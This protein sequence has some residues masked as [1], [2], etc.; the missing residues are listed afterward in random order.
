MEPFLLRY[1]RQVYNGLNVMV[2]ILSAGLI[3]YLSILAFKH[4]EFFTDR[5]YMTFQLWVC[6]AFIADFFIELYMSADRKRYLRRRW[7]FLLFSIPYLNIVAGLN[8]AVTYTTLSFLRLIPLARAAL[9]MALIAS[10]LSRSRLVNIFWSYSIILLTTVYIGSVIF[11]EVERA[12]NPDVESYWNA[13]WWAASVAATVGCDIYPVTV[14]GKI[15]CAILPTM[16]TV[17]FPL[18]AVV[19]TNAIQTRLNSSNAIARERKAS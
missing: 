6:Y 9:A 7:L 5:G 17:M 10:Y 11:Y 18:I 13:L 19:V 16:G 1:K 15:V 14:A 12:V 2:L 3:V 8:I 4:I